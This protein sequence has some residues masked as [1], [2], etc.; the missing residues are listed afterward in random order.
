MSECLRNRDRISNL[1]EA[2]LLQILSLLPTKDVVA[3]SVLSKQWRSLW[4]MVPT[5]Y[6]D[7]DSNQSK[8]ETFSE[9]VSRLLL[10]HKAP[11]LES[12]HTNL[13]PDG[14]DA[15]DIGMWIGIAYAHHVRELILNIEYASSF[16]FPRSL[17]NCETLETLILTGWVLVDVPSPA[18]LKSLRTLH[19]Y[20]VEYKDDTSVLNLLS[21]CPKLENLVV[22]R[23]L[24]LMD[25]EIFS[26]AVPSLQ[27][28]T[29]YDD[30]DW[31]EFGGYLIKAPCLKYLN[32]IW[33]HGLQLCLIEDAPELVEARIINVSNVM[34]ENIMGSLTSA[35]RLCLELSPLKITFPT[36]I[37]FYRLV[38]LELR[39]CRAEW[40]NLLVLMLNA[41]PQL[42]VLKLISQYWSET[43]KDGG[44]WSQP[45]NVPECL[46]LHLQTFL[47][48]GYKQLLKE[49][50]EVAKYILRNANH[51]KKAIFST[52]PDE[53]S[54]ILVQEVGKELE[55]VVRAS[56][57]CEL[58]FK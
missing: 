45:E 21:G 58:V 26:I 43:E 50:K 31:Q 16:K 5:L 7:Y 25:V 13:N 34:S 12:L 32:I 38:Y 49:E 29:I 20:Y 15:M 53:D 57:S 55:S 30:N 10:S 36:G 54:S 8:H 42:Q 51:L 41:S 14:C 46:L 2:L 19:L 39:T 24:G 48:K 3:T 40:W 47:W 17:Y 22:Q 23:G 9:I 6:F 52:I 56:N 1:P 28:L 35:K 4:K 11:F 33:M 37:I 27:R 44:K 18:R